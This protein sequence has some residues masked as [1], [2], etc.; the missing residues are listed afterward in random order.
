MLMVMWGGSLWAPKTNDFVKGSIAA[1][2]GAGNQQGEFGPGSE[3]A[4]SL[5]CFPEWV[6]QIVHD[7]SRQMLFA[8]PSYPAA[9]GS[10]DAIE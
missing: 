4:A 2:I 6:H 7:C 8:V 5:Q 9:M 10:L 1:A 3:A